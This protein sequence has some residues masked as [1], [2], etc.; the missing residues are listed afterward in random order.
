[1]IGFLLLL[2]VVVLFA[3]TWLALLLSKL[4]NRPVAALAAGTEAISKGQ[5]DYRVDIRATDELAEL[6][7]SFNSMAEQL[8]SSR[9]Q[10]EASNRDVSAANDAFSRM[11]YLERSEYVSP[12]SLVNLPLREVLPAEVLADMEPLL[13]RAD[14]MG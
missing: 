2:T 6:V 1:Y 8:E 5:L 3:S 10:I 14:R 12:A 4:V 11:F 9:R 7:Q 13:R